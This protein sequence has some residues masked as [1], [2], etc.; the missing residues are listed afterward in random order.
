[1]TTASKQEL[2]RGSY[3]CFILAVSL[4]SI[5]NLVLAIV[6]SPPATREVIE[7]CDIVLS[8]ILLVDFGFRLVSAPSWRSYLIRQYGWLDLLGSLPIQLIRPVRL[9]RIVR[10][11]RLLRN[12]GLR[13]LRRAVLRDRAGSTLLGVLFL[14]LVLIEVGSLVIFEIEGRRDRLEHPDAIRRAVV[15]LRHHRHGRLRR[16]LPRD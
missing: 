14:T 5:V 13:R 7:A 9:F 2:K 15:D 3:E 1:M 4:L 16:P 11:I 6:V 12:A 8:G 10:V